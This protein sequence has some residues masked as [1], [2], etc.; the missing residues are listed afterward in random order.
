MLYMSKAYMKAP[1]LTGR[2]TGRCT[3]HRRGLSTG[4]RSPFYW[5]CILLVSMV[6]F[7]QP[8]SAQQSAIEFWYGSRQ[9]FGQ[10]GEP[11]R[12]INVL[13]NVADSERVDTLIYRL[14]DG[15]PFGLSRGSDLHRLANPGDFNVE[16]AWYEVHVGENDLV[17]EAVY[18]DGRRALGEV[19]LVVE[20]GNTWPLPYRVDFSEVDDLQKVVQVID[21][22]WRLDE[23][24][25]RT[26]TPYYDRVIGVGDTT[27]H[28]YEALVRLTVHGFTPSVPGPPT[29]NVTHFGVAMRWRGHHSDPH[30]PNRKWYPMGS[31]GELL[32]K[33]LPENSRYRILF[34]SEHTTQ[35]GTIDFP[36]E[37]GQQRWVRTQVQTLDT[38]STRYRFKTWPVDEEEPEKWQAEGTE[39]GSLDYPS[40]SL[41]IVPHNS[42]VTIHE[43]SATPLD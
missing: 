40:G 29:Y 42:D 9:Y 30:Q 16:F 32:L 39:P 5:S 28:D 18:A 13:G 15:P 7:Q 4:S 3:R 14:N 23:E 22:H 43:V 11:Q 26:V 33:A 35:P 8:V 36:V 20:R 24:G 12:W 27:W 17:V 6:V 34:G 37:L 41:L 38:D 25:V 1:V 10:N 21:G 19:T 31:Q 2:M